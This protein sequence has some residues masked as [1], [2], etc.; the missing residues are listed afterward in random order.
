MVVWKIGHD[1]YSAVLIL[2]KKRLPYGVVQWLTFMLRIREIPGS[3]LGPEI[4]YPDLSFF[5][6]FLSDC[7]QIL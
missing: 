1:F 7:R 4:G 3:N 2:Y 6:G 5:V